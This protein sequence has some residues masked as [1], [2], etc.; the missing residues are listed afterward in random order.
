MTDRHDTEQVNRLTRRYSADEYFRLMLPVAVTLEADTPHFSA[1]PPW[2]YEMMGT[3]VRGLLLLGDHLTAKA[4]GDRL[5]VL[6]NELRRLDNRA[7]LE[8]TSKVVCAVFSLAGRAFLSS[9][10]PFYSEVVSAWISEALRQSRKYCFPH[11]ID[12]IA[13]LPLSRGWMDRA[14]VGT[15]ADV[16]ASMASPA[17]QEPPAVVYPWAPKPLSA[18]IGAHRAVAALPAPGAGGSAEVPSVAAAL[19][20]PSGKGSE[21]V[22]S[23]VG[24]SS[25]AVVPSGVVASSVPATCGSA[26]VPSAVSPSPLS[27]SNVAFSYRLLSTED[28]LRRVRKVL[29][30]HIQNAEPDTFMQPGSL[31]QPGHR[32]EWYYVLLAIRQSGLATAD[33]KDSDFVRQMHAWFPELIPVR[34]DEDPQ[35]VM[36]S[37]AKAISTERGRWVV[38]AERT[39]VAIKDLLSHARNQGFFNPRTTPRIVS[40]T[41]RLLV[42]LKRLREELGKLQEGLGR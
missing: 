23:G 12:S 32:N 31:L 42:E 7:P 38:G 41:G 10:Q 9:P 37:Y 20:V 34:Q 3:E 11:L 29:L 24:D 21:L 16:R 15:L 17:P 1:P 30:T 22:P 5:I 40:A 39:E 18:A 35:A 26:A 14:F 8:Q 36:R 4:V 33:L 6:G 28:Q 27:D 13:R 25:G 19:P 2:L